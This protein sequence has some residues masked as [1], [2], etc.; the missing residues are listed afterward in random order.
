MAATATNVVRGDAGAFYVSIDKVTFDSS[1]ATGGYSMGSIIP[2][3]T[4]LGMQQ[5]GNNTAALGYN[6]YWNTATSKLQVTTSASFTPTATPTVTVIGSQSNAGTPLQ[7]NPNSG[8]AGVLGTTTA[9]GTQTIAG[10]TFGLALNLGALA[11]AAETE[12]SNGTNLSTL[13]VSMITY[14]Y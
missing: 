8:N 10:S 14:G 2:I 12:V 11:A 7:I 1:Y 4:I 13:T 6:V 9:V 3:N 5:V